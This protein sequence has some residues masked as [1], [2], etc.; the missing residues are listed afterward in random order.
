MDPSK[1][2]LEC[3]LCRAK[4]LLSTSRAVC[5]YGCVCAHDCMY[6]CINILY[7]RIGVLP[8]QHWYF[9]RHIVGVMMIPISV[10]AFA[11]ISDFACSQYSCKELV[12]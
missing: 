2:H 8:T 11:P 10:V 4:V 5:V 7:R 12:S 6:A 3:P 9:V 1:H